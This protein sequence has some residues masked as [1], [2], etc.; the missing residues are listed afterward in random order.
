M[1]CGVCQ[2]LNLKTCT[3]C[4]SDRRFSSI[5][6]HVNA[7]FTTTAMAMSNTDRSVLTDL[8]SSTLALLKQF[9][10]SLT[11]A[12]NTNIHDAAKPSENPPDPLRV[13]G[14]SAKLLK[15]HTTKLSLLAINKP[16][17]PSA[18]TKV[19]KELVGTC[20]PGMM[21]AVQICEQDRARYGALL[22][23]EAQLRVR[24]VFMELE[25]L[26]NELSSIAAGSSGES[27]RDSL[28]STGVVWESCDALIELEHLGLGGLALQKV[29]QYQETIKDALKELQEWA[30]GDDPD[31]E[32]HDAL[33]DS[34]DEGVAGDHDSLEDIF[35]A[36]NSMPKDRP[37]LKA[38][39]DGADGKLKKVVMLYA[40]LTKRRI[41]TF[42]TQVQAD[43]VEMS[44]ITRLDQL[45]LHLKRIPHQI[46]ELAGCF[47]D[48][49]E[50]AVQE[51]LQKCLVEAKAADHA[52]EVNWAGEE[53]EF[54]VWLRKWN[55]AIG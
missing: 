46:D 5:D 51:S 41:K 48:L 10:H 36:A 26:L 6:Q 35:N 16:F 50:N 15:A 30:A 13:L 23:K 22:S 40:A 18:I 9:S 11:P 29:E 47:Y 53:D 37:E 45:M 14:D 28:S 54:T 2:S 43:T 33:L 25:M 38:L 19:L 1:K 55:A 27:R 21:S 42:E 3:A 4:E 34:D 39:L 52:M 31:S 12:S 8:I 20:L 32:G 7:K 49:D 44:R 24:R 17:T